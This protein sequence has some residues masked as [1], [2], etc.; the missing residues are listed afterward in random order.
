MKTR[1]LTR[2][3]ELLLLAGLIL[4][5]ASVALA[6]G[7]G[8]IHGTITDPSASSIPNAA[9]HVTGG[10]QTRDEKTDTGGKFTVAIP[11]GQYTVRI[12]APGFVTAN[13]TNVAVS[14]GQ[15]ATVDITL[16]IATAAQ[17]VDVSESRV[18]PHST[19]TS[20]YSTAPL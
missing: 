8:S 10:G 9:I 18:D 12:T 2:I 14:G 20:S 3:A 11:P 7:L 1:I 19:P 15:A 17:L 16:Q 13:Q 5:F 4:P 6:Q